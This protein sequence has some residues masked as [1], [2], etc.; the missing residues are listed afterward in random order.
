MNMKKKKRKMFLNFKKLHCMSIIL[1][2]SMDGKFTM[3]IANWTLLLTFT[4]FNN[5][6][7]VCGP[8]LLNLYEKEI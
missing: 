3:F 6:V 8:G 2:A 5:F 4:K 1:L 7:C